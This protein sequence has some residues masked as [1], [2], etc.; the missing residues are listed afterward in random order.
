MTDLTQQ[1]V[2]N[3]ILLAGQTGERWFKLSFIDEGMNND[4]TAKALMESIGD[5]IHEG[6]MNME[7]DERSEQAIESAKGTII[8]GVN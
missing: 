2:E 1:Q 7:F 3:F 5:V 4:P 6:M 8:T